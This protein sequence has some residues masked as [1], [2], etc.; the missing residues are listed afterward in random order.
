MFKGKGRLLGR[1][2]KGE[3]RSIREM[4]KVGKIFVVKSKN[5]RVKELFSRG[6]KNITSVSVEVGRGM[7][8]E[9]MDRSTKLY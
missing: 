5:I 9:G 6:T 3:G 2:N 4:G 8:I 1:K 7:G